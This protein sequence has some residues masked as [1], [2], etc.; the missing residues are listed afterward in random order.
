MEG[1]VDS[2]QL[3]NSIKPTLINVTDKDGHYIDVYPQGTRDNNIDGRKQKTRNA[4][5]GYYHEYGVTRTPPKK[6][7]KATHWM[8]NTVDDVKDEILDIIE[9][10]VAD[11]MVE[12]VLN[13]FDENIGE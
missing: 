11:A 4:E 8:S 6:S 3:I 10:G 1:L 7:I 13:I 12:S 9:R 2:G 5:I